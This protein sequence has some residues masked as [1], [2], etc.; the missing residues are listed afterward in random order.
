MKNHGYEIKVA[1]SIIRQPKDGLFW[2]VTVGAIQNR[3]E[4]ISV[5][6]ALLD[7]QKEIERLRLPLQ[8]PSIILD[9]HQIHCGSFAQPVLIRVM[10]KRCISTVMAIPPISGM[11]GI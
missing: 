9:T 8:V 4:I 6:Q 11:Q 2:N 10:V 7:A 3:N 5:S 1:T